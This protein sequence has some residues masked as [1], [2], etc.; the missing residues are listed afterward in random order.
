LV[1][2]EVF[3]F[4]VNHYSVYLLAG[5]LIWNLYSQ[6]TN[7]SMSSLQGNGIILRKL[8]VPPSVFVAS[9]IGSALVNFGFA[10]APFLF[11][12]LLNGLLP[13][14]S[15]LFLVVPT[16]FAAMFSLGIGLIVAALVAFFTDTFEI[17]QVLLTAYY[18]LTP[19]FYP[20]STLPEPLRSL[21][22]YNPMYLFV[23][24]FRDAV[25]GTL[26]GLRLLLSATAISVGVLLVGWVIFTRVEDKFV[27]QF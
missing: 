18:F 16:L 27:Y 25:Q 21:E 13:S 15:W 8:Y 9:A 23:A 1:F 24:I 7:A 3:R 14:V 17:Y 10:L 12:A 26:P 22:N 11:L 4:N 20:T 5:T 2:S 6:G 19:I